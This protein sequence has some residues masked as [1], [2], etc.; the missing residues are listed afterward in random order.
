MT[1]LSFLIFLPLLSGTFLFIFKASK[2]VVQNV[3]LL[4]SLG[5]FAGTLLLLSDFQNIGELQFVG[6]IPW[7]ESYGI[8]YSLGL[9]GFSMAIMLLLSLLMPAT[10]IYMYN[11]S[12]K[13]MIISMLLAQGGATGALLSLDMILFYLFWETMLLPIFIMIGLYGE[14]QAMKVALRITLYTI[15]GSMAMLLAILL[16]GVYHYEIT[17]VW[18]FHLLD[19]QILHE[20]S[21]LPV[22]AFVAFLL[23]FV[24]KIPLIGF[25]GWLKS[26]Y[27]S[28]PT[29]TIIILSGIMAKLGVYAIYRFVFMLFPD[30]VTL[31]A[32]YL[33]G[34]GIVGLIYFG[35][36]ALMQQHLKILFAYSS[37]SHMALIVVGLFTLNSYGQIGALYLITAHALG[38][39][40]IYLLIGLIF[41]QTQTYHIN[42]LSGILKKAPWLGTLFILFAL[43]IVGIPGSS[44]FVAELLIIIGTFKEN[45][46][47]G[48]LSALTV[49]IAMTFVL[50]T[51]QRIIFGQPSKNLEGFKDISFKDGAFLS[52]IV[53]LIYLMGIMPDMFITM[54]EP[55][56]DAC[57]TALEGST[58]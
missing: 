22:W 40:G 47:F 49:I 1:L 4:V 38:T 35:L 32:P 21:H 31:A 11:R 13:V 5:S 14:K 24:I 28:A 52:L 45:I 16:L 44:G 58:K 33:I 46:I 29:P 8:T 48:V 7:I 34:F 56:F 27:E 20:K 3:S 18:S 50:W 54:I 6:K 26:A 51:L 12:K 9:D 23:A 55:T 41:E 39:A 37:A 30:L 57:L 36:I 19:L 17:G 10:Y 53:F 43:S 2:K 15:F 42:E 25:H